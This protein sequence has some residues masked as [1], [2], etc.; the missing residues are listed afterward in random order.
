L[1]EAAHAGQEL[2]DVPG[3]PPFAVT[4][5]VEPGLLLEMDREQH[6]VVENLLEAVRRHL[7]LPRKQVADDLGPG[8]GADAVGVQRR[9]PGGPGSPHA[10]VIP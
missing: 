7:F 1:F 4:D 9:Q 2:A 3:P 8:Q 5:H 10:P 6:Q